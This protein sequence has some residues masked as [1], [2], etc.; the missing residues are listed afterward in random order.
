[1]NQTIK[2]P[3]KQ[4]NQEL[5]KTLNNVLQEL[6]ILTLKTW[7]RWLEHDWRVDELTQNYK[8]SHTFLGITLEE[9][10]TQSFSLIGD[11]WFLS[12]YLFFSLFSKP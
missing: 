11:S 12:S 9:F 7:I 8:I 10:H 3:E 4:N 6:N 1:M 5:N 2:K